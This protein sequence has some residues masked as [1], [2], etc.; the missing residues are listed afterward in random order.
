MIEGQIDVF[1]LTMHVYKR[2]ITVY[3]TKASLI[4]GWKSRCKSEWIEDIKKLLWTPETLEQFPD[5]K[6]QMIRV[7]NN[8]SF[9]SDLIDFVEVL[10]ECDPDSMFTYCNMNVEFNVC[11][12]RHKQ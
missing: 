6:M 12:K 2:P 10:K 8:E 3:P 7:C 9:D 4:R 11:H 5:T 1:V